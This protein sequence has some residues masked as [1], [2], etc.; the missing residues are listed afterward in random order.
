MS[1]FHTIIY[2]L[3]DYIVDPLGCLPSEEEACLNKTFQRPIFSN[4]RLLGGFNSVDVHDSCP[5]S[6]ITL[7]YVCVVLFTV[8]VGIDLSRTNVKNGGILRNPQEKSSRSL[9]FISV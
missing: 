2:A 5:L 1:D 3:P 9:Q 4:Q 8:V 7:P 6:I